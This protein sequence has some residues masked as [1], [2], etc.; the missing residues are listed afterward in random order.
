[1]ILLVGPSADAAAVGR[2]S[3]RLGGG[4]PEQHDGILVV[5]KLAPTPPGFP[6]RPGVARK[7]PLA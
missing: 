3:A 7:R 5:P 4:E 6:R 1:V 2:A